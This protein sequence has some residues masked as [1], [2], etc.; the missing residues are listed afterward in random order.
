MKIIILLLGLFFFQNQKIV[1]LDANTDEPIQSAT[2]LV[3]KDGKNIQSGNTNEKGEF[4]IKTFY[5]SII[6]HSIGYENYKYTEKDKSNIIIHL[7]EKVTILKEVTVRANKKQIILGD[8]LKKSSKTRVISKEGSHFAVLFKNKTN[9]QLWIKSILLNIKRIPNTTDV[10]FDFYSIDTI[11]RKYKSY[12]KNPTETLLTEL[13]PNI[14]KNLNS[15]QY[16]LNA[17]QNK[18]IVEVK[19]DTLNLKIPKEG[20]FISVYT[21]NIY[22]NV[23]IK[24]PI[25]SIIQLPEIYK[26]KTEDNNYCVFV[27]LN[28]IRWQ[29]INLVEKCGEDNDDFHPLS[30][31]IYYEPSIGLKVEEIA[32]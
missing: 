11:Q 16:K 18:G 20:I 15:Y 28:D 4:Y 30:P 22:D 6:V 14:K 29:N 5:D 27:A 26:H 2:I 23:G 17:S 12:S 10:V 3:Y 21:K 19:I 13:I 32:N 1:V 9:K 25:T 7:N 8:Y 31:M 24:I